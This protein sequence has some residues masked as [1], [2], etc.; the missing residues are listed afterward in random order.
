[1]GRLIQK[2]AFFLL[3]F[4]QSISYAFAE[5]APQRDRVVLVLAGGGARGVAHVGVIRALEEMQIPIDGVAGTSMGALVGGLYA[6][7]LNAAEL[8]D[9]IDAV[10]WDE[11]FQDSIERNDLPQRR[12]SDDYD[13]PSSL[14][15]SFKDG[16]TSLPL[17]FVQ[18]QQTRQIIKELVQD[19]E[20]ISDFDQFPTP[21]RAVATDLETGQAYVFKKGDIVTAMRASMSIPGLLAPVEHD[22][23]LLVDGGLAMNIPVA[24]GR[25]MGAD[26][27][28]VIDI[29]TPLKRREDIAGVLGVTNQ[30]LGF[31]TRRNSLDQLATLGE[32]DVLITPD[33]KGVGMLDFDSAQFVYDQGY[34]ATKAMKDTLQVLAVDDAQWSHYL[35]SRH[36]PANPSPVIDYIAIDNNSQLSD[37]LI[38]VR[39]NQQTGEPF[40]HDLM[41][42][43]IADVYALDYW[44]IIDYKLQQDERGTGLLIRAHTKAWGTNE[45]KVGINMVT[46]MD[47]TS[48]FNLGGSYLLKGINGLGGEVYTRAQM[49][50][51]IL[52]SGE[53]YQPLDV[54]SR[55]FVVPYLGYRDHEVLTIGPDFDD[56][57]SA[58]SWRIRR[59]RAEV[60][61]GINL[62]D[63][64]QLRLGLFRNIGEYRVDIEI[65][66]ELPEEKFDE[67]GV[68]TSFL[69]DELDNLYFP[70]S[71]S[72]F[73]AD[74]ELNRRDLGADRNFERWQAIAQGAI[75]FGA[76]EANTLIFTARTGQTIHASNEPQNYFQLGGLFNL[77][78]VGQNFFSGRQMAFAM[79]QYQRRLSDASLLP[80]D[81]PVYLGASLEGGQLWS[82]RSEVSSSDLIVAGSVYLVLDSPVGPIYLAYGRTEESLDALYLSLGWPFLNNQTRMGR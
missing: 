52:F 29:G 13:Y 53:L 2:L 55:F 66:T 67:G 47:G 30:M 39:I 65:G 18:G 81:M 33:L 16:K 51:T 58:G 8:K 28:I 46:D 77:S 48:D 80:I 37:E 72:F 25:K 82:Q 78:G 23:R 59:L 27:L 62:F 50:D 6:T 9:I 1:M 60:A 14:K 32:R 21:Y 75:S 74:Y 41:A 3:C 31:L 49:G 76:E 44:E 42:A 70:T 45:L 68:I 22:D 56:D 15:L 26:R 19:A 57:N 71:G 20:Y 40:N 34:E 35:A 64:T 38:R 36:L 4:T 61:G 54:H 7:G 24:I 5:Q 11:A 43:D 79:A 69:F 63:N 17:G 12:K 73:Y 10:A